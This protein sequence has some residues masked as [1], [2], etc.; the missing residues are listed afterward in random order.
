MDEK[1]KL[2]NEL[3]EKFRT[4]ERLS[5]IMGKAAVVFYERWQAS[6]ARVRELEEEL[7]TRARTSPS[8]NRES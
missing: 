7:N 6:E 3:T 1:E 2:I 5:E 4:K 8:I